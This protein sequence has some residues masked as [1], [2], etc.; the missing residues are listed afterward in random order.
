MKG[1]QK[2]KSLENEQMG[3]HLLNNGQ[4]SANHDSTKQIFVNLNTVQFISL[5]DALQFY[6]RYY[7]L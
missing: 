1:Q 7:W 5:C 4:T 3:S 6:L 2:D